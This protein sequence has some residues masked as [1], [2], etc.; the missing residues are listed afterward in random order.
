MGCPEPSGPGGIRL[1]GPALRELIP[2]WLARSFFPCI[3]RQRPAKRGRPLEAG[4]QGA[5]DRRPGGLNGKQEPGDAIPIASWQWER[6]RSNP[7]L[8]SLAPTPFPDLRFPDAQLVPCP[9]WQEA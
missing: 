6:D 7:S 8:G 5:P 1:E 3:S 4:V 9:P 2:A